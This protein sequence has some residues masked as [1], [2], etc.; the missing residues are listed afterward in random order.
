MLFTRVELTGVQC[1]SCLLKSWMLRE[2]LECGL[3]PHKV[4][5]IL[6]GAVSAVAHSINF[7]IDR[8]TH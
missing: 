1:L 6:N 2:E 5:H 4:L 3:S 8:I 7:L